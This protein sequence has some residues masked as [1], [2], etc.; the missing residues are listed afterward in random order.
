LLFCHDPTALPFLWREQSVR[1][2]LP[3]IEQTIIGHLHSTLSCAKA[4]CSP[5]CP[6]HLPRNT[7]RRLST[8]LNEAR[9][10]R[11]FNIRLCPSLAASNSSRRRYYTAELDPEAR[12]PPVSFPPFATTLTIPLTPKPTITLTP[13]HQ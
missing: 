6:D 3:Q 13:I 10:W 12:Q 11:H 4:D 7:A 5:A 8:A 1:Q 9:H 2:K